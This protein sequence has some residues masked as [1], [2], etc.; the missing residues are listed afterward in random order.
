MEDEIAPRLGEVA[1][2]LRG[3]DAGSYAIIIGNID[4]RLVLVADGEKRKFDTAKKKNRLHLESTDYIS[5]EV[6]ESIRQTNRVTNAK[7]RYAIHKFLAHQSAV[8]HGKGD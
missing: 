6:A 3:R 5:E 8:E 4:D 1:K 7:L 2:V